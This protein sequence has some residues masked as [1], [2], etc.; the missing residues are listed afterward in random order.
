MGTRRRW[1]PTGDRYP[2]AVV[3]CSRIN[4]HAR[5]QRAWARFFAR[6]PSRVCLWGKIG[7][8]GM[9]MGEHYPYPPCPIA[10]PRHEG[11]GS[12]SALPTPEVHPFQ[13]DYD[14]KG[15]NIC[16]NAVVLFL[17]DEWVGDMLQSYPAPYNEFY[18][19]PPPT[20]Q[21]HYDFREARH[22]PDRFTFPSEQ[23][24]CRGRRRRQRP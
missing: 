6:R 14:C 23:L 7:V 17:Q 9:G 22:S 24:Q 2:R 16:P 19:T 13:H 10:I 15:H 20:Q 5:G 3:H 1:V 12:Q 11:Q 4:G 8:A 18:V 21:S